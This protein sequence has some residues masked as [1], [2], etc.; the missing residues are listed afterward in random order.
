MFGRS[1]KQHILPLNARRK[2]P[3]NDG[4]GAGQRC[5]AGKVTVTGDLV[6]VCLSALSTKGPSDGLPGDVFCSGEVNIF[7]VSLTLHSP[8][9]IFE[10][11]FG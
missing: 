4:P 6:P 9:C 5:Q 3:V 1:D 7:D 2:R 10:L 8:L 11:K